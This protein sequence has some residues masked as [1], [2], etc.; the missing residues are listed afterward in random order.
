M[1]NISL[2]LGKPFRAKALFRYA[3][4]TPHYMG[5]LLLFCLK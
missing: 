5:E 1:T 2:T 3:Q 4:F